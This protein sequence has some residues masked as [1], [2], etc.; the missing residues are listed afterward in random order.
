[1]KRC[2]NVLRTRLLDYEAGLTLQKILVNLVKNNEIG[3]TLIL[4][5]HNPVYTIGI[6]TKDYTL[7]DEKDLISKGAQFYRTN[8]GGLITF[9]GPGQMV[10]YPILFLKN[11]KPSVRWYVN[12]L[13][14]T[15]IKTC[16]RFGIVANT[17]PDTGVWVNDKKICAIGI[18][19]SRYVT[20]HGIALN[21]ETDLS[22][23]D[24]I[25]PCGIIGKGVTSIS[26]ELNQRVT[27]DETIPLF[28][29][30]FSNQFECI[31]DNIPINSSVRNLLE[32]NNI[33]TFNVV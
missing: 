18:H 19:A 20:S 22:W 24:H 2:V 32:E 1:M 31:L 29:T 10:A 4:T 25:V 17:S 7:D 16:N 33:Q 3:N 23:F 5:E 9:H 28:L 26:K 13:E 15:I 6:R 30:E 21:C 8:R 11:F 14:E 12:Q 27:I